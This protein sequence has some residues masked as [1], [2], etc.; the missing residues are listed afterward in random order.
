MQYRPFPGGPG[1]WL[2]DRGGKA[3]RQ[4][5]TGHA[6]WPSRVTAYGSGPAP[7]SDARPNRGNHGEGWNASPADSWQPR[8]INCRT[9]RYPSVARRPAQCPNAPGAC[10]GITI[11]QELAAVVQELAAVVRALAAVVQE[12]AVACFAPA[13][14]G[15]GTGLGSPHRSNGVA[16]HPHCAGRQRNDH[17]RSWGR[18][19]RPAE[20]ANGPLQCPAAT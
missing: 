14:F 15:Q 12:P 6:E 20:I 7:L 16:D 4:G 10:I 2:A 8:V 13:R 9:E 1:G 5:I 18:W 3:R 19:S 11:R 17:G